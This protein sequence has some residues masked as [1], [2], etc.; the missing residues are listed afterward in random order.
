[1]GGT[2]TRWCFSPFV[3]FKEVIVRR[4]GL[5]SEETLPS[6]LMMIIRII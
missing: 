5:E 6:P 2:R 3:Y 1:M 4:G